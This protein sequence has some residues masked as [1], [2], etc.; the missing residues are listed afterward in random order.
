[1][2]QVVNLR[3]PANRQGKLRPAIS[4][5]AKFDKWHERLTAFRRRP[6][7]MRVGRTGIILI[8][9]ARDDAMGGADA[10]TRRSLHPFGTFSR[11]YTLY[12]FVFI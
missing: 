5:D 9:G 3:R 12:I 7:K 10:A 1:V 4:F 2:G 6:G 11:A 8:F